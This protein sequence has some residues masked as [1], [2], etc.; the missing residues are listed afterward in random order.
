MSVHEPSDGIPEEL[1]RQ[2]QL[3]ML[4]IAAAARRVIARRRQAIAEAE[5]HSE[6]AARTLRA[7]LE[8]ERGLAAANLQAVFDEAWWQSASTQDVAS[9]WEQATA[10]RGDDPNQQE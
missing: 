3:A 9:M 7:Q 6:A 4:A 1:E 2:L 8:D 5:L 10:W